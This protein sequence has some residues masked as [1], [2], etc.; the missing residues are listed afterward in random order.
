[1]QKI[2]NENDKLKSQIILPVEK[3]DREVPNC[4]FK[5]PCEKCYE[6][7]KVCIIFIILCLFILTL[8]FIYCLGVQ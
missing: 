6:N 8:Y 3:I 2:K 7:A 1:M 4:Q 5:E